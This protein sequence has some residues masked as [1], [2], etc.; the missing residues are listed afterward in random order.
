M[1]EKEDGVELMIALVSCD[2]SC[3]QAH[4]IKQIADEIDPPM[5][6]GLEHFTH[7]AQHERH[8]RGEN[9]GDKNREIFKCGHRL[10]MLSRRE[11]TLRLA[12]L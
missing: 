8:A 10:A 5:G 4:E 11:S 12:F 2:R 3:R 1:D 7:A 9:D 6:A